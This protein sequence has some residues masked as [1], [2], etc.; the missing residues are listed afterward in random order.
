MFS[1]VHP[2]RRSVVRCGCKKGN[3][4]DSE[5]SSPYPSR[6]WT[7]SAWLLGFGTLHWC[8]V[9]KLWWQYRPE[10]TRVSLWWLWVWS[11]SIVYHRPWHLA[12]LN[13]EK[14][15]VL[16]FLDGCADKEPSSRWYFCNVVRVDMDMLLFHPGIVTDWMQAS[17]FSMH[18]IKWWYLHGPNWL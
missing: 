8:Y 7:Y 4:I 16:P 15:D 1:T 5:G 9:W 11:P 13:N 3:Q 6:P 17:H 12:E 18:I 2:P 10:R 14:L